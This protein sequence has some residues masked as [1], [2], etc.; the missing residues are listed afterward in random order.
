MTNAPIIDNFEAIIGKFLQSFC[1]RARAALDRAVS[2]HVSM[3][4]RISGTRKPLHHSCAG[5]VIPLG[6]M[7][8]NAITELRRLAGVKSLGD[9]DSPTLLDVEICSQASSS[10]SASASAGPGAALG[11]GL[12][13]AAETPNFGVKCKIFELDP[14]QVGLTSSPGQALSAAFSADH[15]RMLTKQHRPMRKRLDLSCSVGFLENYLIGRVRLL[16]LR[17]AWPRCASCTWTRAWSP[18]GRSRAFGC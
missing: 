10:A 4:L 6:N 18:G 11:S 16:S 8:V 1:P 3:T 15:T 13:A 17:R 12:S 2:R 14:C 5:Q 9:A 7:R